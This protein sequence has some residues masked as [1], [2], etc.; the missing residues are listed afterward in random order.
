MTFVR[1]VLGSVLSLVFALPVP[2]QA[3][4][5]VSM[6]DYVGGAACLTCHEILHKGFTAA[7]EKTIH[8]K[9]FTEGN[10]LTDRMKQGCEGCHGPG[11]EH[12][13]AG[14]GKGEKNIIAFTA[15]DPEA[16]R[17]ESEVC[18]SCHRGGERLYWQG[19]VHPSRDVGC[20][21]YS[22]S[23]S[24]CSYHPGARGPACKLAR[25]AL[26]GSPLGKPSVMTSVPGTTSASESKI[27]GWRSS[28]G[29]SRRM[30]AK[31]SPTAGQ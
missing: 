3:E 20:T 17:S 4:A 13:R 6:S 24:A 16:I 31:S 10:A 7:Y 8:A 12:V 27:S 5:E 30:T 2:A 1:A 15:D 25:A 29:R 14:G 11:G 18:L 28:T 9:V 19:S 26:R 21:S 23:S 22:A